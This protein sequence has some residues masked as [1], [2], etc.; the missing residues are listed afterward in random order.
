MEGGSP[1][2]KRKHKQKKNI[3]H[4]KH[5]LIKRDRIIT[6]NDKRITIENETK[7]IDDV[8]KQYRVLAAFTKSHNKW[9]MIKEKQK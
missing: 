5:L 9:F 1:R 2:K 4:K 8:K 6:V 3:R 7:I